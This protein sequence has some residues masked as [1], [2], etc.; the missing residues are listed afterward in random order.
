MIDGNLVSPAESLSP[1][2]KYINTSIVHID[3]IQQPNSPTNEDVSKEEYYLNNGNL[4]AEYSGS[5]EGKFIFKLLQDTTLTG[6]PERKL[7]TGT[8]I[9]LK[10]NKGEFKENTNIF[11]DTNADPKVGDAIKNGL[12]TGFNK[13]SNFIINTSKGDSVLGGAGKLSKTKSK[14]RKLKRGQR[15]RQRQHKKSKSRSKKRK[16]KK[17]RSRPNRK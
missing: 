17:S 11:N 2:K 12:T 5:D 9:T 8:T 3:K 4:N 14:T 1:G 16:S 15:Q 13:L 6:Q 10:N 7:P